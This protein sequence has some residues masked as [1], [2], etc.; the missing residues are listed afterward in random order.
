MR[1]TDDAAAIERSLNGDLDAYE[2]LVARYT[3]LAHR[4][5]VLLGAGDDADDVVQEAFVKAYRK[6]RWFRADAPFRP[7]L[8]RIVTNETK[9][10]HRAARRR[11]ALALR[12]SVAD[13]DRAPARDPEGEALAAERGEFLLEAV[14]A[15][16]DKDRL[17]VTCRYF[18]D[19][20]EAETAEMLGWRR[21]T[22][23]S[24]TSRALARLRSS[25]E[26]GSPQEVPD[27]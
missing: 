10:L 2:V 13:T 11:D 16:P 9:N 18:L 27:G 14:R 3:T 21:G 25:V 6:L 15:L 26:S 4:T 17:V 24:R 5:A 22:V 1:T 19:L 12:V 20:G 7:W 23:K 8:L